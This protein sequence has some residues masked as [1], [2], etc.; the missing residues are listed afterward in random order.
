MKLRMK[1][2]ATEYL[3]IAAGTAVGAVM[4]WTMFSSDWSRGL[5]IVAA[6]V[7]VIM[8]IAAFTF[9]PKESR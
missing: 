2:D 5:G 4:A 3:S 1:T 8:T 7:A 6:S 9:E